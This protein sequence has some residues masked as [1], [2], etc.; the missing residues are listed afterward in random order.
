MT[1]LLTLGVSFPVS[2]A[3]GSEILL[4]QD[5]LVFRASFDPFDMQITLKLLDQLCQI[6]SF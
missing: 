1:H 3:V 5:V 6:Q 2:W 4:R